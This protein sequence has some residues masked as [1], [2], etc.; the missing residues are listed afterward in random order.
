MART[1]SA[2]AL[3]N[4]RIL[5][6]DPARPVVDA[7]RI[8]GDRI[9]TVG[10]R[11]AAVGHDRDV[12]IVDL[13]G[14]VV[15]PGLIDGH[16]HMDREGLRDR[17]PS[18]EHARS[19]EDIVETIRAL[20]ERTPPGEWIVTMPVGA[21]PFYFDPMAG[22]AEGRLPDR[23]DLD[24]AAPDH[25]VYIRGIWGYWDRPPITSIANSAALARCG[26]DRNAEPPCDTVEILR[27]ESGDPTGVFR[28]HYAIPVLEFTLF[29]DLPRF[30]HANRVEGIRIAQR[31]YHSSG[32]TGIYEAHGVAPEVVAA[33]E[34]L[35]AAGELTMRSR[36]VAS[37]T[38]TS[39][40]GAREAIGGP[41]SAFSGRHGSGD[42]WLRTAGVFVGIGE[43]GC[44][45]RTLHA[46]LPYTGWAGFVEW[47]H[48]IEEFEAIAR[49]AAAA[50]LR[51][52]TLGNDE[53]VVARTLAAL[54]RVAETVP[55]RGR[56]W[57]LEHLRFAD[58]PTL[59]RIR[60]LGLVVTTQPAG[61]IWKAGS[62]M[63]GAAG[64]PEQFVPHRALEEAGVPFA[65]STDD[66][67]YSSLWGL[68]ASVGRV[69]RRTGKV[70]GPGQRLDVRRALQAQTA[71]AALLSFDEDERGSLREGLLADLAIFEEDPESVPVDRLRD[72]PVWATV[73]G[74]RAVWGTPDALEVM[75]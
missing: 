71:D 40:E 10:G 69:D 38:W 7:L 23:H 55:V 53:A 48:P 4:G 17:W 30:T 33:Y 18:L 61:Y 34:E 2:L 26:I 73:V 66:K 72:L 3:V 46:A 29:R 59:D 37:P 49:L 41:L 54:E 19:I 43:A 57:V 64:D 15:T 74:G 47:E 13:G 8:E 36:L 35:H 32:V 28:E 16:A 68:W 31:R 27:D 11:D 14:R 56:R 45:A 65:L 9:A 58:R 6:M 52:H 20:A 60:E 75:A 22:L 42:E 24:R 67:P 44:V 12:R 51:V 63:V 1:P 21:P 70:L 50:N 62:T 5:T 25:P 39:L